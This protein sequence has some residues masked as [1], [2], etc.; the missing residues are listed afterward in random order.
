MLLVADLSEI[1]FKTQFQKFS[2]D[3]FRDKKSPPIPKKECAKCQFRTLHEDETSVFL[4][5]ALYFH[6]ILLQNFLFL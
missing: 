4:I 2:D 3:Y 5:G 1:N 6:A